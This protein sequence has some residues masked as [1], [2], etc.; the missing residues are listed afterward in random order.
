MGMGKI[1]SMPKKE[2]IFKL[3]FT[4][5]ITLKFI[6]GFSELNEVYF[7]KILFLLSFISERLFKYEIPSPDFC[8][9]V[10]TYLG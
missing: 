5:T 8:L 1:K 6:N 9:E 7:R 10:D 3:K 2:E 4:V